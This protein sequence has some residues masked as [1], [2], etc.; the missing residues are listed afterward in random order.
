MNDLNKTRIPI[1]LD[2]AVSPT[3]SVI[4]LVLL[5]ALIAIIV[6]AFINGIPGRL[7]KSAF[8]PAEA[9]V[10]EINGTEYI[11]INNRGGDAVFQNRYSLSPQRV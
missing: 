7:E 6:Y 10:G 4:L 8:I 1:N 9:G 3:I 11:A 2:D 5:A